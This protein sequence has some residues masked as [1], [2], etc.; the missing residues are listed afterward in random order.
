MEISKIDTFPLFC[1]L[2]KP[3]G[4]ANGYKYY[5]SCYLFRITTQSGIEGWGEVVDWLPTLDVG[6]RERIIPF[7]IGKKATQK[8]KLVHVIKKWNQRIASGVSM[9]LTEIIAKSS[10]L[11][12]CDLWGGSWRDQVPVYASFQSYSE[13]A[14][15]MNHSLH[16]VE[17]SVLDGY[18]QV[19]VKVG[20]RSLQE[21]QKHIR[22]LQ[23][24]FEGNIQL[25]IDA[26]QSY[27]YS[28]ACQWE[29]FF[30]GSANLLWFEEPLPLHQTEEYRMLRNRLSMPVAG[31]ENIQSTR[32][33]LPLLNKRSFDIIQPDLNHHPGVDDF[34]NTLNLARSYGVRC[35][36]HAF[37]GA[38]SRLY[39]A[40]AQSC[41]PPWTKMETDSV[42]PVEWD[43]MENP[44]SQLIPLQPSNGFLTLPKGIGIGV[45]I[46]QEII[47]K[48]MWDG[49]SY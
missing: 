38:L 15:W 33:F 47:K 36:P 48:Y 31:G 14:D 22:L 21:D 26:N 9:A 34:R 25:A 3:Y 24:K 12:V 27:D 8:N 20:G 37:D 23:E 5:R 32:E 19:K 6:F 45:E 29:S 40:F 10:R 44:F 2:T 18:K 41:L 39:M 7:L 28:T 4:D 30:S 1:R 43:V 46:N 35:S 13:D 16:L 42:E 49:R 11:S 17:Q